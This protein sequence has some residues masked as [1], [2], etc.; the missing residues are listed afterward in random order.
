ME[1]DYTYLRLNFFHPGSTLAR[2]EGAAFPNT[3]AVFVKEMC[4]LTTHFTD[5]LIVLSAY[6]NGLFACYSTLSSVS[7]HALIVYIVV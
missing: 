1:G 7:S 3:D 4:V 2:N 5:H 6:D